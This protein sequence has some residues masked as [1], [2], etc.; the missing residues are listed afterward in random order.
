MS[1][2][3]E[4]RL[5]FLKL[6]ALGFSLCEI[7]KQLSEKYQTSPRNIY[8]DAENRGTWQ[9]VLTQLFDLDKARLVVTNRYEYLYRLASLHFQT[10]SEA[11]KPVYLARMVEIT[12][13]LVALLGLESLKENQD[14]KR[15]DAEAEQALVQTEAL[16]NVARF[17]VS[18]T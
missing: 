5:D 4:R 16:I 13:R 2:V 12:D 9:P 18:S 1:E 3:L 10:A 7:V 8:Y 17:A 6:E 11:Q 14:K 15:L